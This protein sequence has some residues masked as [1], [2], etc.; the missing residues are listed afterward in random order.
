MYVQQTSNTNTVN[1]ST[2]TIISGCSSVLN[3]SASSLSDLAQSHP[4]GLHAPNA[5]PR[6]RAVWARDFAQSL[7]WHGY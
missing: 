2:G 6:Y 3:A 5:H 4:D 7:Q 1:R